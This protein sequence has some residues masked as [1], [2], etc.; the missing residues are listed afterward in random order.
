MAKKSS[1]IIGIIFLLIG[2]LGFI[3]N[4]VIGSNGYF[5]TNMPHDL[6]HVLTGIVLLVISFKTRSSGFALR[7]FGI[8]YLALAILGLL[9]TNESGPGVL[10]GFINVNSADNWIHLILGIVVFLLGVGS[11]EWK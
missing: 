1:L 11:E 9:V 2:I 5:L 4:P 8:L 7:V 10:L 6:I 3:N